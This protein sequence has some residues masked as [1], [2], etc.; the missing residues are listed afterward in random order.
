MEILNTTDLDI[1]VTIE[2]ESEP[3]YESRLKAFDRGCEQ[4]ITLPNGTKINHLKKVNRTKNGKLFT[5]P[6]PV[7]HSLHT[8]KCDL[9][10]KNCN[11]GIHVEY[12]V[13]EK[14]DEAEIV[15]GDEVV[16]H[17]K[18]LKKIPFDS[19][20]QPVRPSMTRMFYLTTYECQGTEYRVWAYVDSNNLCDSVSFAPKY[21][22]EMNLNP[23]LSLKSKMWKI[24]ELYKSTTKPEDV[25]LRPL[26]KV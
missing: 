14:K 22:I 9:E 4:K 11:D 1:I 3:V 21:M 23:K 18:T 15:I 24:A 7:C 20:V 12:Y 13:E 5:Y 2:L 16:M 8:I 17:I 25:Q 26:Q 6:E 10:C 19:M